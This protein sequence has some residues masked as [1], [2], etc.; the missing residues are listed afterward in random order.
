[1]ITQL[2]SLIKKI[3]ILILMPVRIVAFFLAMTIYYKIGEWCPTPTTFYMFAIMMGKTLI[4]LMSID[5]EIDNDDFVRY[6]QYLYSDK[7]FLAVFNHTSLADGFV[8]LSTFDRPCFV[9]LKNPVFRWF[10]YGDKIHKKLRNI[11]VE[12][13]NTTKQILEYVSNRKSGDSV[14]FIAPGSG[15][16]PTNPDNITEFKGNGAFIGKYPILPV[17][18]K[19]EDN[20]IHHNNDNGE[21]FLHST[22]KLFLL[23][24]YK[25]KLKI[26]DMIEPLEEESIDEYKQRTYDIMNGLYHSITI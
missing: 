22:I 10:G 9:M 13:N 21:S 6:S 18:M 7:K 5:V 3:I 4:S 17:L 15:N 24:N 14:L 19:F 16:T 26:G 23:S 1:M 20:S 11:Y 8:L 25:I 2:F 12:K